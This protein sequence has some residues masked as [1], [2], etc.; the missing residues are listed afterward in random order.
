MTDPSALDFDVRSMI[1]FLVGVWPPSTIKPS[2]ELMLVAQA[3]DLVDPPDPGS[4]RVHITPQGVAFLR[5][6][7]L[8]DGFPFAPCESCPKLVTT[9][10]PDHDHHEP[11]RPSCLDCEISRQLHIA[12]LL[13]AAGEPELEDAIEPTRLAIAGE[14]VA[15][16]SA[17]LSSCRQYRYRLER[18]LTSGEGTLVYIMLNPSTADEV[19]D[20]P[21][22]VKCMGFAHRLGFNK[23]VVVNLFAWRSTDPK[24]LLTAK[25]P[26]GPRNDQE[27]LRACAEGDLV[28]AAWGA[29]AVLRGRKG[30]LQ[31]R[32]RDVRL[33]VARQGIHLG[34]LGLSKD[35][36]PRHPLMLA[37]ATPIEAMPALV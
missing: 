36:H 29:H 31:G 24:G 30:P 14:L 28:L 15:D 25:D 17:V 27:I 21:T 35:N 20:D 13:D 37:Y 18:R 12:V 4:T 23:V 1:S 22:I 16:R 3:N 5:A 26:I 19:E 11:T 6:N 34:C 33:L 9:R 8:V 2:P 10:I 7:I 32:V